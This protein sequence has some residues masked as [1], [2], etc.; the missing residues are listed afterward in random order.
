V[1][2]FLAAV[3][4]AA[5]FAASPV[6]AQ[7]YSPATPAP[8]TTSVPA[9]AALAIAREV[10]ERFRLGIEDQAAGKWSASA[11]EFTRIVQLRPPEPKGSTAFYD[12]GLAYAHEGRNADAAGAFRSALGLDREFLAAMANLISVDLA[13]GN[14][15]EARLVA[16]NYVA[17]APDSARAVYSRG[18]V[19]LRGGDA[20]TARADFGKLLSLDPAYAVAHY[21][22][23][24]AEEALKRYDSAERELRAALALA[25]NYA[26]A[27]FALGVVL[28]AQNHR[29]QAHDA[30]VRAC[31]LSSGDP[32]LSNLATS[33]RDSITR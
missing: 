23:A 12:L 30:F 31:Q 26:R 32:A 5:G 10:E 6:S 3:A 33:M 22:L 7:V 19:A 9:L 8:R 4:C 15:R 1:R 2:R 20:V 16:D 24:L 27:E 21:G 25:P 18:I 14:A 11:A 28:L 17:V 13:V 29:S